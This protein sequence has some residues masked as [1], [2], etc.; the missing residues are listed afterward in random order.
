PALLKLEQSGWIGSKWGASENNRRARFYSITTRG[1]A[2]LQVEAKNWSRTSN[3]VERF[4]KASED[5][6]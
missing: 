3:I 5:T 1:R 6:P 2:Q 4:L